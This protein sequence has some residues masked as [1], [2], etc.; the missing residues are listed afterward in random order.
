MED[1]SP[2]SPPTHAAVP[3]VLLSKLAQSTCPS[4]SLDPDCTL[5]TPQSL[6]RL[7]LSAFFM[8]FLSTPLGSTLAGVFL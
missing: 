7:T 5:P 8:V 2:P 4:F 1:T 6:H 3:V